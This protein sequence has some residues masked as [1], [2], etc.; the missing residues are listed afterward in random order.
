MAAVLRGQHDQLK[1]I[2]SYYA[3]ADHTVSALGALDTMNITEMN[4]LCEVHALPAC[5]TQL[6]VAEGGRACASQ[7]SFLSM[8]V[9]VSSTQLPSPRPT[10]DARALRWQD[11]KLYDDH[12]K[13]RNMLAAFVRVNID[14]ELYE[15]GEDEE[16]DDE[17]ELSYGEFKEMMVRIYHGREVMHIPKQERERLDFEVS[18][19][20]WLESYFIPTCNAAIKRRKR[21]LAPT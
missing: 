4:E 11:A 15:K 19:R 13:S 12:F 3:D 17:S 6:T 14:D 20:S 1:A 16:G 9:I 5:A 21:G 7:T 10:A 2:F 18:F 8:V